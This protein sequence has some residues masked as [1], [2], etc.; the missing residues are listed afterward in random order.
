[1]SQR[2]THLSEDLGHHDERRSIINTR[3]PHA[4]RERYRHLHVIV[5][6]SSMSEYTNHEDRACASSSDDRGQLHQQGLHAAQSVKAIR[7][8]SY[9]TCKRKLRLDN[10]REYS[11]IEIQREYC[12]WRR[13]TSSSTRVRRAEDLRGRST[14]SI[15]STTAPASSIARSLGHEAQ[16]DRALIESAALERP[17]RVLDQYHDIG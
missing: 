9:D 2:A 5:G 8:I 17:A 13:S 14:S 4:D 1:V 6:D 10:G 11:P 16:A 15:A 12:R 7:D 3:R